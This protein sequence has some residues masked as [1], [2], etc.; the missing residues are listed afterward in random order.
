VQLTLHTDYALRVLIHL[1]LADGRSEQVGAIAEVFGISKNHLNKV[2]QALAHLGLVET[3][4]GVGGGVRL[5]VAPET[6]RL[7]ALVRSLEPSRILPCVAARESDCLIH[8]PCRLRHTLQGAEDAFYDAL[9][10]TTL[11]DVLEPR[12][13][14]QKLLRLTAE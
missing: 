9:D 11:A 7:G 12:A 10:Q 8:G 4:R 5:A 3:R 2:V 13:P 1:G 6:V 14:L